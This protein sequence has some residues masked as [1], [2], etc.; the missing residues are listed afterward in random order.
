MAGTGVKIL[1]LE[2]P[3]FGGFFEGADAYYLA[4]VVN[5]RAAGVSGV[6]RR[7]GL[8]EAFHSGSRGA[9]A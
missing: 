2:L 5:E 3:L 9:A 4:L 6:D 7:V 1:P 8:D